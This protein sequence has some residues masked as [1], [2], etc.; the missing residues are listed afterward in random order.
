ML[1]KAMF[2]D[3]LDS[4]C[5]SSLV[6]SAVVAMRQQHGKRRNSVHTSKG[7]QLVSQPANSPHSLDISYIKENGENA[8]TLLLHLV[9]SVT[10][11]DIV[12]AALGTFHMI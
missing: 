4:F 7:S 9:F 1:P 2:S 5:V 11:T 6:S 8:P 12:T 10:Y 3:R